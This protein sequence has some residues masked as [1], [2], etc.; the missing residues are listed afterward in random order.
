[1]SDRE[2]LSA[3]SRLEVA[4]IKDGLP[5][6]A[7]P[8][9]DIIAMRSKEIDGIFDLI[10]DL[11]GRYDGQLRDEDRLI[12][13][14]REQLEKNVEAVVSHQKSTQE[15]LILFDDLKSVIK[16]GSGLGRLMKWIAGLSFLYV[17]FDFFNNN[18]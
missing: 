5:H 17:I 12:S 2:I 18:N 7:E 4:L 3:S 9:R 11:E 8:L 10:R 16:F 6:L 1:M 14:L 13:G 15:L